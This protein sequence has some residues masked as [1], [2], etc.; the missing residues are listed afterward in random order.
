[1]QIVDTD[2]TNDVKLSSSKEKVVSDFEVQSAMKEAKDKMN[3]SVHQYPIS[4]IDAL[5]ISLCDKIDTHVE[6][7][8]EWKFETGLKI[9]R[10]LIGIDNINKNYAVVSTKVEHHESIVQQGKGIHSMSRAIYVLVGIV[11][12]GLVWFYSHVICAITGK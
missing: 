4:G 10:A 11:F 3:S 9:D 5:L 12:T 7:D 2:N 1:M 8:F 6:K